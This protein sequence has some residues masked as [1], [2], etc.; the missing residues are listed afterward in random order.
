MLP[1]TVDIIGQDAHAV[2]LLVRVAGAGHV[3]G[4]VTFGVGAC[5]GDSSLSGGSLLFTVTRWDMPATDTVILQ[6]RSNGCMEAFSGSD[7]GNP[8]L[9]LDD[10][11][12]AFE[13]LAA[14]ELHRWSVATDALYAWQVVDDREY[15]LTSTVAATESCVAD[16]MASRV[17]LTGVLFDGWRLHAMCGD[18]DRFCV[19]T[20][21]V[22]ALSPGTRLTA[23]PLGRYLPTEHPDANTGL[24]LLGSHGGSSIGSLPTGYLFVATLVWEPRSRLV[25]TETVFEAASAQSS[26]RYEVALGNEG[27][28]SAGCVMYLSLTPGPPQVFVGEPD[29]QQWSL[30]S[31][32]SV[33]TLFT[34]TS[35]EA[36]W[37]P[38]RHK[39]VVAGSLN[40]K[41]A[42]VCT[43]T[44]ALFAAEEASFGAAVNEMPTPPGAYLHGIIEAHYDGL[45]DLATD[46]VCRHAQWHADAAPAGPLPQTVPGFYVL[47]GNEGQHTEGALV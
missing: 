1:L 25:F 16:V 41:P 27:C 44:L 19:D 22:V 17:L 35:D 33:V 14:G 26:K 23:S 34:T 6:H 38:T 32:V 30:F 12:F 42:A 15:C 40:G 29:T 31:T 37:D 10:T 8:L 5:P 11:D 47:Y 4:A 3:D 45:A 2:R 43:Q 24:A 18:L 7:D 9:T 20:G 46:I 36:A 21:L 28:I 13:V 39:L